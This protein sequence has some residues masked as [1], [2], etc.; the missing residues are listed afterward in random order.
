MLLYPKGRRQYVQAR[1]EI[2]AEC[3]SNVVLLTIT[4][5]A[6]RRVEAGLV[7]P[8]VTP[9]KEAKPVPSREEHVV[10]VLPYR[11][12]RKTAEPVQTL[13]GLKGQAK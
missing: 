4:R 1:D 13:L 11:A 10:R 3:R 6:E 2:P 5:A 9:R 12:A 8:P 7:P